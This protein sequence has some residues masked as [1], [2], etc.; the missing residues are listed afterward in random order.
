MI[1][2]NIISKAL[3]FIMTCRISYMTKIYYLLF[4]ILLKDQK[5]MFTKQTIYI[6]LKQIYRV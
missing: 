3:K 5:I 1:F 2:L 4:K 6:L